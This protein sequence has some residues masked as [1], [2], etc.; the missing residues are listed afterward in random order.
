MINR[1]RQYPQFKLPEDRNIQRSPGNNL[2]YI[3]STIREFYNTSGNG[4]SAN[5]ITSLGYDQLTD[6]LWNT[7]WMTEEEILQH[8]QLHSDPQH[9]SNRGHA[10][11]LVGLGS[12]VGWATSCVLNWAGNNNQRI[13]QALKVFAPV[14]D[15]FYVHAFEWQKTIEDDSSICEL[16]AKRFRTLYNLLADSFKL[17][18]KQHIDVGNYH[19]ELGFREIE[20]LIE[21]TDL[22]CEPY[23][24]YTSTVWIRSRS[25]G[26]AQ[27]V[28]DILRLLLSVL[29]GKDDTASCFRVEYALLLFL[30]LMPELVD[31]AYDL[32]PGQLWVETL[33]QCGL[34]SFASTLGRE[35]GL[36]NDR[37]LG[38][39]FGGKLGSMLSNDK[40]NENEESLAEAAGDVGMQHGQLCIR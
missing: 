24:K 3:L 2:L 8:Q 23:H 13:S 14:G 39:G 25:E 40:D 26:H 32:I 6:F 20:L 21:E 4:H 11:D 9:S 27:R 12:F 34:K 17:M 7:L 16:E 31:T 28:K 29:S 18:V 19:Y 15:R 1:I 33:E 30:P 36:R 37:R 35:L 5:N 22:M 38:L 10:S